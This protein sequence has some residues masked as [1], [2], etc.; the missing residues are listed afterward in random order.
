MKNNIEIVLIKKIDYRFLYDLLKN[1]EPIENISHKKMPTYKQHIQF[2]K[3]KPYSRWYI[4]LYQKEKIGTIYLSKLDEIGVHLVEQFT[5]EK[6]YKEIISELMKKNHRRRYLMN[7]GIKNKKLSKLIESYG[8][9]K[10]Q[11]TFEINS[12]RL[13]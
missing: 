10:I 4:I 12:N 3:S 6:L 13:K 11:T 5:G 9:N 2:I 7:V 8:F 1:R